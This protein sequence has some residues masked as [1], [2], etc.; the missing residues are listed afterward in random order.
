MLILSRRT[1][2]VEW[3]QIGPGVRVRV[4]SARHGVVRLGIEAPDEV[5]V[6]RGPE[7][8]GEDGAVK[9]RPPTKR[10]KKK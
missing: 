4:L 10:R 6:L 3:I 2:G 8:V 9:S 1:G 5:E 7:F